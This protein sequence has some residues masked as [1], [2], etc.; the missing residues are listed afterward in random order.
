M[1]RRVTNK[2]TK[3]TA[4]AYGDNESTRCGDAAEQLAYDYLTRV[5]D[6]VQWHREDREKQ[7]A[8]KDFEF[9]KKQWKHSYSVDVKGNLHDGTF[10]VYFD[11]MFNKSNHRMMH[12]DVATRC[13]I[14]YSRESMLEYIS[15]NMQ[16]IKTDKHDKRYVSLKSSDPQLMRC[17]SHFRPFRVARF[18]AAAI[19]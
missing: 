13:A 11:E 7:I 16:L 12:V 19:I 8:G 6:Q 3:T 18:P 5:Y 17:I 1:S 2:W 15:N 10:L 4:Q 9:K 14:E